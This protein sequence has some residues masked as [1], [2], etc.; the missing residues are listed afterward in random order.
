MFCMN[1]D[2]VSALQTF[3]KTCSDID[4]TKTVGE[5]VAKA[6]AQVKQSVSAS[7]R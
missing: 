7:P 4:L 6:T 1:N 5:N 2:V 3:L